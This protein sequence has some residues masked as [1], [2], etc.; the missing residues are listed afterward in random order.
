MRATLFLWLLW[1]HD[2]DAVKQSK[3]R[4]GRNLARQRNVVR[5]LSTYEENIFARRGRNRGEKNKDDNNNKDSGEKE[6]SRDDNDDECP[7]TEEGYYEI[8]PK[9]FAQQL[10]TIGIPLDPP[11]LP[12]DG[13]CKVNVIE[14][15]VI[16]QLLRTSISKIDSFLENGV[17]AVEPLQSTMELFRSRFVTTTGSDLDMPSDRDILIALMLP[18][19]VAL[20]SNQRFLQ[21]VI[22]AEDWECAVR[23]GDFVSVFVGVALEV[24]SLSSGKQVAKIATEKILQLVLRRN[25]GLVRQ[26]VAVPFG[27]AA[28]VDNFTHMFLVFLKTVSLDAFFHHLQQSMTASDWAWVFAML[29]LDIGLI[30]AAGIPTAG[31]GSLAVAGLR[32]ARIARAAISVF[33]AF[34][35]YN[36]AVEACN[37]SSEPTTEPTAEPTR[38]RT[39][40]PTVGNTQ[41]SEDGW[42]SGVFGDPHIA[43]FDGMRFD[44]Q[45][46]GE[47]IMATVLEKPEKLVIQERFTS[48]NTSSLCSQASVST[49]IAV[50]DEGTPIVQ[51]SIPRAQTTNNVDDISGTIG[52]CPLDLF[53][54]G[55][56][57]T[58]PDFQSIPISPHPDVEISRDLTSAV[59]INYPL[60]GLR[61]TANVRNSAGGFGCFLMVQVFIPYQYLSPG[62]TLIGLLGKANNNRN[63]DWVDPFGNSYPGPANE[64]ESVFGEAYEYCVSNWCI[65]NKADSIF[66]YRDGESFDSIHDCDRPYLGQ[67][68]ENQIS[69]AAPELVELCNDN[70]ICL[71]DG[72]C[73]TLDDAVVALQDNEEVTASQNGSG[74]STTDLLFPYGFLAGDNVTA[75]SGTRSAP[76]EAPNGSEITMSSE[77][78]IIIRLASLPQQSSDN[79]VV[80]AFWSENE[81]ARNMTVSTIPNSLNVG[82]LRLT[83]RDDDRRVAETIIRRVGGGSVSFTAEYVIVATWNQYVLDEM[84][85]TDAEN[86]FQL[87][88][89]YDGTEAWAILSYGAIEF[90]GSYAVAGFN[91]DGQRTRW[92]EVQGGSELPNMLSGTN[93]GRQGTYAFKL[94]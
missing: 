31:A 8:L 5:N 42:T 22:S 2:S 23:I 87:A 91:Y 24:L 1:I 17:D 25:A 19:S 16:R 82:F 77:G 67:E 62:E 47:F 74:I 7:P 76:L 21:E 45:G 30:V 75:Y 43:T 84:Y 80:S 78:Y 18:E 64:Q 57:F 89:T 55:T 41:P 4:S 90:W 28:N 92:F 56:R 9:E 60:S 40:F 88:I 49:A 61:V 72:I 94:T 15:D 11:V 59:I 14:M 81:S 54:D 10:E 83:F 3:Q 86:T 26:L 37:E 58:I 46:V 38:S 34:D 85:L 13:V 36:A 35:S 71:I 33:G 27:I 29:I 73:G 12:S 52:N 79:V 51:L 44:C 50:A 39:S 70:I 68:L 93:C 65:E 6:S 69:N 32:I 63:D 53:V 48:V 20:S 66:T